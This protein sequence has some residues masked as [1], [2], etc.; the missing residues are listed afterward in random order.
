MFLE[1]IRKSRWIINLGGSLGIWLEKK[2]VEF[3]FVFVDKY[4]WVDCLLKNLFE[5][6]G[7]GLKFWGFV[8]CGDLFCNKVF[9]CFLWVLNF[10]M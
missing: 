8:V 5:G 4:F 7:V 3:V 6:I 9:D 1:Y 10:D 2:F